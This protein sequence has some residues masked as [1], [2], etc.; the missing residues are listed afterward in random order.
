MYVLNISCSHNY[1]YIRKLSWKNP[2]ANSSDQLLY[3]R[4]WLARRPDNILKLTLTHWCQNASMKI[5][6]GKANVRSQHFVQRYRLVHHKTLKICKFWGTNDALS[7]KQEA[8]FEAKSLQLR[9]QPQLTK[10]PCFQSW[11]AVLHSTHILDKHCHD[12][13]WF[14]AT[15]TSICQM[16]VP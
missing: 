9:L 6:L 1:C 5:V 13:L 15:T 16:L 8:T 7:D 14:T 3:A 10:A 12:Q 11:H 2:R 4:F